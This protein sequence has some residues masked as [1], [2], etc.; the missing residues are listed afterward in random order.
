[1]RRHVAR[2]YRLRWDLGE[3]AEYVA[4]FA[5]PHAGNAEDDEKWRELA[6]YLR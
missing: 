1:M 4:R 6:L 3:I 2:F 5:A